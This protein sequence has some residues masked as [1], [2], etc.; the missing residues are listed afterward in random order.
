MIAF[1]NGGICVGIDKSHLSE[2]AWSGVGQ[3]K[4]PTVVLRENNRRR[5]G[6]NK[7]RRVFQRVS[8]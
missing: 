6:D 3:V 4:E 5:A 2:V 8:L 1:S 7:Y